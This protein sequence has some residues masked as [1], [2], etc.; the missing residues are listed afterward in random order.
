MVLQGVPAARS[1]GGTMTTPE[2]IAAR[3]KAELDRLEAFNGPSAAT[4]EVCIRRR[5]AAPVARRLAA[6]SWQSFAT[7]VR[8]PDAKT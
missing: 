5:W 7:T 8:Y 1:E 3:T 4:F 2:Q 6:P